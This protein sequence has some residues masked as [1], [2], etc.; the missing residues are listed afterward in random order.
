MNTVSFLMAALV[1]LPAIGIALWAWRAMNRDASLL[2]VEAGLQDA[3][4]EIGTW[5]PSTTPLR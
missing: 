3:D 5:P 1:M 4:V 2:R